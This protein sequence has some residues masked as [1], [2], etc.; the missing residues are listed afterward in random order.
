MELDRVK[1]WMMIATVVWFIFA[2]LWMWNGDEQQAEDN[3]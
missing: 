3:A 2:S 1:L